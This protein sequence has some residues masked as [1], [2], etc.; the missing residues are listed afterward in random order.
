[1]K[2]E[3]KSYDPVLR[4]RLLDIL[5][6][7]RQNAKTAKELAH[8]L[9]NRGQ[10]S[11]VKDAPRIIRQIVADLRADGREICS[12]SND[13]YYIAS[14]PKELKAYLYALWHRIREQMRPFNALRERYKQWCGEMAGQQFAELELSTEGRDLLAKALHDFRPA[15]HAT[16][17]LATMRAYEKLVQFIRNELHYYAAGHYLSQRGI[18]KHIIQSYIQPAWERARTE[19]MQTELNLSN[20][21]EQ[22]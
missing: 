1:M 19:A 7:G 9:Q 16:L 12:D 10:L 4:D 15:H 17:E 13:G 22:P 18:D 3:A 20:E 8:E 6:V 21:E 5:G 11:R 2:N 14:D